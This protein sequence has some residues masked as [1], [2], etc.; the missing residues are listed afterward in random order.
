MANYF[1]A[2]QF[3]DG[4]QWRKGI[5]ATENGTVKEL[6][7]EKNSGPV[8]SIKKY[9]G[10]FIAPAFI[11]VQIYGAHQRLLAAYPEAAS[12]HK[13]YEYCTKGGAMLFLPTVAT[14]SPEVFKQC[15]NA[16]KDYWKEGGQGVWGLHLEGPWINAAKKGAHLQQFIHS[17]SME[18]VMELINYGNGVVKMITLAP[19]VCRDEIVEWLHSQQIVVSAGHTNATF[20]QATRSFDKGIKAVTHLYNAMSPLQHRQPGMAGACM[21]HPQ[22]KASI[23]ADGYHVDFDAI[24]IAKKMMGERLFV[25][26][27]AVT[28]TLEGPYQ[29]HLINGDHY[30]CDGVL[31]GSAMTMHSSFVNLVKKA[32]I[33]VEEALRMCSL[34][35]AE[36]LGCQNRHG[37]IAP[38]FAAQFIVLDKDLNLVEVINGQ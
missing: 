32:G 26:T 16:V 37:K 31:S 29:H 22:V 5:I 14:N 7:F 1:S 27:D 25:I 10:C 30:E 19:E 4:N 2:D 11:D 3:F 8:T 36:V 34:Y 23:I 35:P 9:E 24:R 17:P 28:E 13:L 20:Q 18:E 15:I 21:L 12:L 38:G 6:I 33:E